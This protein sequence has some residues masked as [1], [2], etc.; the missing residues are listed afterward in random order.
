MAARRAGRPVIDER[1]LLGLLASE[2]QRQS[3]DRVQALMSLLEGHGHVVMDR[4]GERVIK[5]QS[6]MAALLKA[7]RSDTK[8]AA[9]FKLT[10]LELKIRQYELGEKFVLGI[11]R[12]AGWGALDMAWSGPEALPTLSEIEDPDRWLSRVA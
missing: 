11:E 1:G 3:L 4:L 6:R 5:T 8:S 10:G 12:R 2:G 9:F 7:R